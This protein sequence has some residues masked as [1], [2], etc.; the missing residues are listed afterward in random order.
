MPVINVGDIITTTLK[1]RTRKLADNVTENNA[2]LTRLNTKG[3]IKTVSGGSQIL[4]ELDYAENGTA[5]WYSGY[6]NLDLTP[7]HTIDS[8]TFD[9]KQAAVAV[10]ISGLEMLKNSGK[11]RVIDL[12]EARITNAERTMKNH[13]STGIYSDGTGSGGL[14]IGGLQYLVSTTPTSGTVGGFDRSNASNSFWRNISKTFTSL[15][16]TAGADTIQSAMNSLWVDLVRGNDAPDLIVADNI[17]WRYYLESLQAITRI[18]SV[19][20]DIAKL[21]FQTLKFMNADVVMDGGK[22]GNCPSSTMYMLNTDYI[23]YRPH[24]D[25]N[26]VSDG[27]VRRSVNQD[28]QAHLIFF[29]GN[30]TLS[31]ASLQGVLSA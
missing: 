25:R 10:T 24:A 30:M 16:L 5:M 4:Q 9:F 27:E 14:Q 2:L 21:G 13:I 15:S 1:S 26:M 28:A 11:E 18:E 12:L 6:S 3:K 31:N 29:A 8:A 22:G 17:Y 20:S 23:H 19:N 7:Q